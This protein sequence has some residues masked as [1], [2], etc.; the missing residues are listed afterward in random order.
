[1]KLSLLALS[2]GLLCALQAAAAVVPAPPTLHIFGDSLSDI[3]RLK[4]KTLGL[5]PPPPY[6]NGRFSSGP[7]WNEYLSLLLGYGLDNRA[8]GAAETTNS[9]VKLL[10]FIPLDIPS[11]HDQIAEF[12]SA[13]PNFA[14][15]EAS[16]VDVAFLEIGSNDIISNLGSIAANK[17][18]VDSYTEGLSNTIISRLQ[19]LK[20]VGFKNIF[21]VNAPAIQY[22]P[23]V[24]LENRQ[25][26]ANATVAAY[27]SKLAQKANAWAQA[28]GIKTFGVADLGTYVALTLRPSVS[29]ALG[30]VDTKASCVGGDALNLFEDDNH[31]EALLKF[32]FDLKDTI[33]CSDPSKNYFFDPLHPNERAHRLFGYYTLELVKARLAGSTYELT[34]AGL[35]ALI[36]THK[37]NSPAPKPA[38]I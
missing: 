22:T 29:S 3:G 20:D 6:W 11:T 12:Q 24:K 5:V 19:Q 31:V 16:N 13:N 17:E 2:G 7:V 27:N 15:S 1:M 18:T 37:L 8:V 9:H 34:E 28:A 21:V 25:Q 30:I 4:S 26:A 10:G 36:Q 35:I 14:Q 23:I 38:K 32:F 33:L